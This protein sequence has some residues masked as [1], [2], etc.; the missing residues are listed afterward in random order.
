MVLFAGLA[1]ARFIYRSRPDRHQNRILALQIVLEAIAVG[2]IGGATWLL[3]DETWVRALGLMA[4]F[5]VWPK[6][7]SYYSF[8]ATLDTPLAGPLRRTGVL[9]GLLVA[10]LVAGTTV[11][12]RPEWYAGEVHYW[13]LTSALNLSPGTFFIPIL[14]IWATMWIAGLTFSLSALRN[15]RTEIG[16]RQA[17]MYL[18]AFGCRDVGLVLCVLAFTVVP[19][20]YER[21]HWLFVAFPSTLLVYY[22]LVGW[23]ILQHQLF[24]IELRLKRGLQRSLVAAS[25]AAGFFVLSYSF[26]QFVGANNFVLGLVVA[27]GIT[28]AFQPLQRAAERLT[29]RVMP[30]VE[31]SAEY[32]SQRSREVYRGAV[33]AAMVD[34]TVT[35]RE[36]AILERLQE[37]LGIASAD[38]IRIE[39]GAAEALGQAR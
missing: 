37:S 6:L 38:A 12:L 31:N 9:S 2:I 8:L 34:G 39:I 13:P 19:P 7:W 4:M 3:T 35:E 28:L 32:R 1:L 23:G 10:T 24:D 30:G 15:A 25:L 17:R 21:F 22:P 5:I 14:W 36:R 16:R 33:E 27:A 20:T 18:I 26:E 29:D 11:F